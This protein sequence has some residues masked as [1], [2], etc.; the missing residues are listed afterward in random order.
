MEVQMWTVK[1]PVVSVVLRF[2]KEAR[3]TETVGNYSGF[4]KINALGPSHFSSI[5]SMT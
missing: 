5:L 1:V 4:N 3:P 2:F